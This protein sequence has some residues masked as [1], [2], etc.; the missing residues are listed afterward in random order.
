[1]SFF[2]APVHGA[3]LVVSSLGD[4]LAP[5]AGSL[6]TA[7]AIVLFTLAVRTLLLPLSIAQL[8]GERRRTAFLAKV[9]ELN[10]RYRERPRALERE[11]ARV[12]AEGGGSLFAGLLP[13]LSQVPFFLVMYRLFQ[14]STVDGAPNGLLW[15]DLLGA[16]LG[17]RL[18]GLLGT[19]P[20]V[21]AGL[22]VLLGLTAFWSGQLAA[23]RGQDGWLVRALPC[24]VVVLALFL[25]LAAG[26]YLLV[27]T[28]WT[29]AQR[30]VYDRLVPA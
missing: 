26:I 23:R 17:E 6:A 30:Q 22:V 24:A 14:S 2:D 13:S 16:P 28:A 10:T 19:H 9:G 8:R 29:I 12:Q 18:L 27:S 3:Y 1:M 4:L 5:V 7:G 21:A 25:P 15:H 11:L 20:L